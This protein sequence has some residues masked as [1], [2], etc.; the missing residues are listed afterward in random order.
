MA[1]EQTRGRSC[2]SLEG[3]S[4]SRRSAMMNGWMS[5]AE[6]LVTL[7][8]MVVEVRPQLVWLQVEK[9]SG[10]ERYGRVLILN[11]A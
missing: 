1:V 11:Q 8:E 4:I 10:L 5:R 6:Q 9:F 7:R 2:P 3:C